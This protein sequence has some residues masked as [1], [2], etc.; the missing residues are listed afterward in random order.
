MT[1]TMWAV[2]LITIAAI[3]WIGRWGSDESRCMYGISNGICRL[4]G[5][6]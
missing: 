6:E 3:F 5:P 4:P 1:K 2:L